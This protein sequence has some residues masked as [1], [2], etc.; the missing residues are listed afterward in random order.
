MYVYI[1]CIVMCGSSR[2]V[3]HEHAHAHRRW[4][5]YCSDS[6]LLSLRSGPRVP[7]RGSALD[8]TRPTLATAAQ[9]QGDERMATLKSPCPALR[10]VLGPCWMLAASA[11]K[12]DRNASMPVCIESMWRAEVGLCHMVLMR[13]M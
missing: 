6:F 10:E 1:H 5:S 4:E 9:R 13:C 7:M 11:T 12:L 8:A 2:Y 3:S